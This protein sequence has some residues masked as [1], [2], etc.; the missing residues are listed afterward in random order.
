MKREIPLIQNSGLLFSCYFLAVI[1]FSLL[2]RRALPGKTLYL[3]RALLPSWRFFED[4]DEAPALYYRSSAGAEDLGEWRRCLEKPRR[5]FLNLLYNPRANYVLAAGSVVQHLLSEIDDTSQTDSHAI[6]SLVSYQLTKN[7]ITY[8]IEKS[9]SDASTTRYQF[10]ISGV[11]ED[12]L[13]S[14]VYELEERRSV[15]R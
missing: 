15:K 4:F 6:E 11:T 7:L 9:H 13:I 12:I 3:F 2:K 10:K 1:A 8:Q 14:P 5:E